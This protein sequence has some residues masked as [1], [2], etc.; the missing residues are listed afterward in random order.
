MLSEKIMNGYLSDKAAING[1]GGKCHQF[2]LAPDLP[3]NKNSQ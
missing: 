2:L 3:A 1:Q